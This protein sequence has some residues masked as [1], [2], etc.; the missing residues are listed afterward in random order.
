MA[1]KTMSTRRNR[2][3]KRRE[4]CAPFIG[5]FPSRAT[6]M[7]RYVDK[8]NLTEAAAGSGAYQAFTPSSLFDPDNTGIGHQ[9]MFF[10][11]LCTSTGP[12]TQYRAKSTTVKVTYVNATSNPC[13]VGWY[14]SPSGATP[15]S[16][17]AAMEKPFGDHKMISG[18]SGGP[19][20][21]TITF[22]LPHARVLGLTPDHIEKDDYYAGAYNS[23]PSKNWYLVF[24]TFGT[25]AVSTVYLDVQ[26]DIRA[27]FFSL[28]NTASS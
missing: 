28:A 20:T 23:S 14:A 6:H 17:L 25:A 21:W 27:E 13:I 11:Q 3:G 22:T 15:A 7:V 5:P 4:R 8:F 24:Y 12:Y 10:D 9:P 26:L 16:Y 18:T 2:R 19:N 1:K